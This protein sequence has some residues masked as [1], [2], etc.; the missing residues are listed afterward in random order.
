MPH[1]GS[2]IVMLGKRCPASDVSHVRLT[3]E[4]KMYPY[5]ST[6]ETRETAMVLGYRCS[7]SSGMRCTHTECDVTH[8]VLCLVGANAVHTH[9]YPT[10]PAAPHLILQVVIERKPALYVACRVAE[11]V[12]PA[13]LSTKGYETYAR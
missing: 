13:N 4:E 12:P 6:K 2:R 10:P 5:H 8:P 11:R 3:R 1:C 9:S 7:T